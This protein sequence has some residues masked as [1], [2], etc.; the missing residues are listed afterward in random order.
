[1]GCSGIW[2]GKL[3]QP[4]E[5]PDQEV[6]TRETLVL[7]LQQIYIMKKPFGP[8]TSDLSVKN[9]AGEM[10]G[11]VEIYFAALCIARIQG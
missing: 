1:M 8:L 11:V 10:N 3:R 4:Y 5:M 6:S 2:L 9:E 7:V